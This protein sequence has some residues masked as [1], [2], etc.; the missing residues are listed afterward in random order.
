MSQEVL[1]VY[2]ESEHGKLLKVE[3]NSFHDAL[4]VLADPANNGKQVAV[5]SKSVGDGCYIQGFN[6]V[7]I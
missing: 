3:A 1:F 4:S 6:L 7:R 5:M 2:L